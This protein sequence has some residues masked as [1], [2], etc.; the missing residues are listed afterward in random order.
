MTDWSQPEDVLPVD[1]DVVPAPDSDEE[2]EVELPELDSSSSWL[3]SMRP[4]ARYG[5]GYATRR[6]EALAAV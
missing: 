6:G 2:S 4:F 5:T 3:Q 1:D